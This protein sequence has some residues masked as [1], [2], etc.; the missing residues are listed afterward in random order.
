M[1]DGLRALGIECEL[2][3]AEGSIVVRGCDGEVP[4]SDATVHARQSGT[5]ARFLTPVAASGEASTI[6]DGDPQLR[7]RPMHDQLVALRDLG[8]T[9]EDLGVP[10]HLPVRVQ[11]P[12]ATR[13]TRAAGDVSSQFISGLMLAGGAKGLDLELTT[14]VVSLPYIQMTQAVMQAFGAEVSSSDGGAW[15]V[16]GGYTSPG[17]FTVEPDASA[18]SYFLAAAAISGGRVKIEGLG[19]KSMQGDVEFVDVLRRMGADVAVGDSSVEVRGGSLRGIDVDLRHISDTAPT[20]AVVAAFAD[21]P[22]RVTGIGFVRGKESDRIGGPV[23]ELRRC[24]V[25]AEETADGF[26]VRP[27]GRPHTAIFETYDD[28]RMAMAFSLVGLIVS[29]VA[30]RDPGCVAKTFPGYFGALEQLR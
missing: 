21:G 8:V 4:G 29:G 2:D 17:V 28:H 14:D 15:T 23:A 10:G 13:T 3:E 24:G 22:T 1:V 25:D 5:T 20:L 12:F 6:V 7:G 16:G 30:V 26:V 11:G 9:V 27:Q 19:R 18:A